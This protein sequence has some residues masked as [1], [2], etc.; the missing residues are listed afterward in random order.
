MK[1]VVGIR[2]C[3]K[4]LKDINCIYVQT[5]DFCIFDISNKQQL[6]CK[7]DIA[8]YLNE[9]LALFG[10]ANWVKLSQN[11]RVVTLCRTFVDISESLHSAEFRRTMTQG[12]GLFL[13]S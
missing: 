1:P 6:Q 12:R 7:I 11:L 2:G 9:S 8:L 10:A 5:A 13:H 4:I 3:Y